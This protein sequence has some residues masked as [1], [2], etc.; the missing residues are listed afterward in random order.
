MSSPMI[1]ASLLLLWYHVLL[2]LHLTA[3]APNFVTVVWSTV[4]LGLLLPACLYIVVV[5]EPLKIFFVLVV[6]CYLAG[7]LSYAASTTR[8]EVV[9]KT[10]QRKSLQEVREYRSIVDFSYAGKRT[11][12]LGE[13]LQLR[14]QPNH[15]LVQAFG[16]NNSFTTFNI[17]VH[18]K[19]FQT[20]KTPLQRIT[21]EDWKSLFRQAESL[22]KRDIHH[23][24]TDE[25]GIVANLNLAPCVRALCFRIV[26]VILFRADSSLMTD[27]DVLN[28]TQGINS[29]WLKSKSVS[30][31]IDGLSAS[32]SLNNTLNRVLQ[33]C[34]PYSGSPEEALEVLL[35]AYETLWRV[36]LL[37][38]VHMSHRQRD[39][40]NIERLVLVPECLATR[41]PEEKYALK[42]AKVSYLFFF[43]KKR[44]K[45]RNMWT[46]NQHKRKDYDSI[47]QRNE[48]TAQQWMGLRRPSPPTSSTVNGTHMYGV[49]MPSNSAQSALISSRLC[50]PMPTSLLAWVSMS[51]PPPPASASDSSP[52]L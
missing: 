22:L 5:S 25:N 30:G 2:I 51:A 18:E 43:L 39:I 7:V 20:A 9:S 47:H 13:R 24:W 11:E 3:N 36:V 50:S 21:T 8:L 40:C 38:F 45:S 16:I 10:L 49:K 44:K 32:L 15:R 4:A 34:S 35:P 42:V 1:V 12:Y 46:P 14:S 29:Q 48:S 19:F 26:S 28:I 31:P 17:N 6:I 27:N 52:C 33:D 37:T 41:T 23:A